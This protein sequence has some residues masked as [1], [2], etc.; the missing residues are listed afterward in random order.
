[1]W[2]ADDGRCNVDRVRRREATGCQCRGTETSDGD[3]RTLLEVFGTPRAHCV[4]RPSGPPRRFCGRVDRPFVDTM[5]CVVR[6]ERRVFHYP[7]VSPYLKKKN[8]VA[9]DAPRTG[10][11][12]STPLMRMGHGAARTTH[13]YTAPD[14]PPYSGQLHA[15]THSSRRQYKSSQALRKTARGTA[16]GGTAGGGLQGHGACRSVQGQ[17]FRGTARAGDRLSGA[18]GGCGTRS[19]SSSRR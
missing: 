10:K 19:S 14:F 13:A 15:V 6:R 18:W 9:G 5:S 17:C 8:L 11:T 2:G 7:H 1:M 4:G 16:G 3:E 12:R